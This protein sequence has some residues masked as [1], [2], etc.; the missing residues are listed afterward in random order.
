ML[1]DARGADPIAAWRHR[2]EPGE[3]VTL[4]LLHGTGGDENS[5]MDLAGELAP[6]ARRLG[7]AGRST[8]EGVRRYFRRF[9]AVEY[10]QEHLA[11]E[12]D[13][14]AS[15]LGPASVTYGWGD[16]PVVAV[17]YSNGAN[18]AVAML[19][20]R[21]GSLAGAALLRPVQPLTTPPEA[22]LAGTPVLITSGARDP[23]AEAGASLPA[24][25]R[26][27]GADVEAHV[28]HAGHEVVREDLRL[29]ERWLATAPWRTKP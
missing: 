29:V 25:L 12:A 20:R 19:L 16:E 26:S 28:L 9:S 22:D 7:V 8:E 18:L 1:S 15:F 13:A 10:D 5:L 17:G 24:L 4:L 21:P 27:R 6:R 3:G 14:L 2:F 11:A 23:Y